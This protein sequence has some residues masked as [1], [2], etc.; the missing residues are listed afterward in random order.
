VEEWAAGPLFARDATLADYYE[1]C[2]TGGPLSF[3]IPVRDWAE[4]PE[5]VRRKLVLELSGRVPETQLRLVPAATEPGPDCLIGERL[6]RQWQD[7]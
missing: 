1:A 6:R 7:P 3:V 5:A 2:V 4:F